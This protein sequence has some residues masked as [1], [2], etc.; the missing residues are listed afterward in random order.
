MSQ[1]NG[2]VLTVA[3]VKQY[4]VVTQLPQAAFSPFPPKSIQGEVAISIVAITESRHCSL[5]FV[6]TY[7]YR[8]P[9]SL[10]TPI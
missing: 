5:L 2:R 4:G 6:N 7:N 10:F 8:I 3:I 9:A 1:V